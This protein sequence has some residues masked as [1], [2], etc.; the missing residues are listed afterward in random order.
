M[1]S[2]DVVWELVQSMIDEKNQEQMCL[3]EGVK[4]YEDEVKDIVEKV[5]E[6]AQTIEAKIEKDI[7]DKKN[8]EPDAHCPIRGHNMV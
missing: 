2:R 3:F 5:E 8:Q 4:K 7:E 1:I 6:L